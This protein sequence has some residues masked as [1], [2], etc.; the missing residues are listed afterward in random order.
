[1]VGGVCGRKW[2][3]VIVAA[4]AA[5]AWTIVHATAAEAS[6]VGPSV[7]V[8][9][10]SVGRGEI[11]EIRGQYFGTGCNDTGG[12]G[13]TLGAPQS[14]ISLRIRQGDVVVPVAVVNAAR[15]Y[16]FVV[17]VSMPAELASGPA[18]VTASTRLGEA[19]AAIVITESAATGVAFAPPTFVV[20]RDS[21]LPRPDSSDSGKKLW[22]VG[23]VLALLVAAAIVVVRLY[24]RDQRRPYRWIQEPE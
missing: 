19:G 1:L 2:A 6:C 24:R 7:G 17:R 18:S 13:P 12:E 15:D 21:A 3:T 5:C 8:D 4:V 14:F 16:R 23:G 11:L 22:V 20:G 9:R 10:A